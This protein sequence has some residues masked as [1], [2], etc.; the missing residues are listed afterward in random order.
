[1]KP[2]DVALSPKEI[3]KIARLLTSY[4]EHEPE[5]VVVWLLTTNPLIGTSPAFFA[6][7]R[8]RKFVEWF[9]ELTDQE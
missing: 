7:M 4:F 2:Y 9:K 3:T 1:M 8:P 5:K 6:L